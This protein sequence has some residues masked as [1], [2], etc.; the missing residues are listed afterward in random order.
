MRGYNPFGYTTQ[1]VTAYTPSIHG[2]SMYLDGT[3]DYITSPASASNIPSGDF[4]VELWAYATSLPAQVGLVGINNTT[5]SGGAN[6][7][8]YLES[9]GKITFFVAGNVSTYSSANTVVTVGSWNHIA[10]ARSGSTNTVYVN[11]VS[12]LT[13]TATPSWSGTP[14]MTVGR[15]FGDNTGVC[16]YG[17]LSDIRITKYALYTSNFLPPLQPL[18]NYS[19]TSPSSLLLNF[20]NGGIVDY[21]S[22]NVLEALGNAQLSTSVKKYGNSSL[23]FSGSSQY[24]IVSSAVANPNFAFGTGDF[25]IEFWVYL[26][27]VTGGAILLDGRP[28]TTNGFYPTIY[29]PSGA[30]TTIAFLTNSADRINS[31][32]S[33]IAT[34]T[35]YHVALSRASSSTKLFVNGTQVGSTYADTNA[36]LGGINRP[37]V[38][39]SGYDLTGN[40]NGYIDDLRITKGFARYTSNFTAPT[41]TLQTF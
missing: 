23:S 20:T 29:I 35:W 11:G 6:F 9:N 15:L 7:G 5:S 21:H 1:S 19:T 36:Y 28:A 34:S 40:M 41:S 13:N 26:N 37:V 4:T 17:Y 14:V 22:S 3:T 16:F 38:A 32:S 30:T 25:T 2:G 24:A 27:S 10:F 18:T 8:L 39:A 12:V 31:A 33:T